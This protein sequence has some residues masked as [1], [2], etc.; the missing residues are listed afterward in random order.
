[1][2]PKRKAAA[3]S[4]KTKPP[5]RTG[6]ASKSKA[7]A[8]QKAEAQTGEKRARS[9]EENTATQPAPKRAATGAKASA[10]DAPDGAGTQET[11]KPTASS[12]DARASAPKFVGK[13]DLYSMSLSFLSE[14]YLPRGMSTPQYEKLYEA[15]LTYQAKPDFSAQCVIPDPSGLTSQSGLMRSG[16]FLDPFSREPFDIAMN[17]IK[18][19]E[20]VES[21]PASLDSC[22]ELTQPQV[23][24]PGVRAKLCIQDGG[25]G[26]N[27][28][29]GDFCMTRVWKKVDSNGQTVELFEGALEFDV[30][31]SGLYSN[32]GHGNGNDANFG[33]WG[34]RARKDQDGK[35]IGLEVGN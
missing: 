17:D 23:N 20:K 3:R 7:K 34:V 13:F 24:V 4:A 5:A 32:K 2:A 15:I 19:L 22:F 27:S 1:M 31:Y 10:S 29:S 8:T 12:P 30:S 11:V 9:P 6:K 25:C 26:I 18:H 28:S 33:F 21:Y 16:G 14:V 35:E